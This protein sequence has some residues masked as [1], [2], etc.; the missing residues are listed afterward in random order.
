[1]GTLNIFTSCCHSPHSTLH[2][3]DPQTRTLSKDGDRGRVSDQRPHP[4]QYSAGLPRLCQR[5]GFLPR[6]A[7]GV[8]A[9]AL[10]TPSK[11]WPGTQ[12]STHCAQGLRRHDHSEFA[13]CWDLVLYAREDSESGPLPG[14]WGS[15]FSLYKSGSWEAMTGISL[16]P[17]GS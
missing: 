11:G 1:M 4:P 3:N 17:T 8:R 15:V 16:R 7:H 2:P 10:G 14:S 5:C 9:D 6:S 12:Q 13:R